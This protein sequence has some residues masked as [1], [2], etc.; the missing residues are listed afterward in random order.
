MVYIG[1]K[2]GPVETTLTKQGI[3]SHIEVGAVNGWLEGER[4]REL[5]R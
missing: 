1:K 5:G 2:E 3:G 4:V